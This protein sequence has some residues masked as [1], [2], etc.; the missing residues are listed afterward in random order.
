VGFVCSFWECRS[1]SRDATH[2]LVAARQGMA[3]AIEQT[4][5]EKGTGPWYEDFLIQEK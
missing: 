3:D 4:R 1:S 5:D 2:A